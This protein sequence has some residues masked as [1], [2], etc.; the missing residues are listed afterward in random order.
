MPFYIDDEM[1]GNT[2]EALIIRL[3]AERAGPDGEPFGLLYLPN[4]ASDARMRESET[5]ETVREIEKLGLIK[6]VPREATPEGYRD[7]ADDYVRRFDED[8]DKQIFF[9][10]RGGL[11]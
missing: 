11:E 7:A 9:T 6:I 1:A 5:L 4:L 10:V 8:P 2:A 3:L